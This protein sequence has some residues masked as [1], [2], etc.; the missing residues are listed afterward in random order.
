[1]RKYILYILIVC[2]LFLSGCGSIYSNYREVEQLL[3]IET[4]GFDLLPGGVR[5]TLASG[6]GSGALQGPIKL[7]GTGATISAA[8]DQ[9]R[10]Y[11]FE[12]ELFCSQT[13]SI[14]IGEDAA[15][16]G[17]EEYL[18]YICQ[19]PILRTDVPVFIIRGGSAYESIMESGDSQHGVS[20]ILKGV[21]EYLE[22]RGGSHIFKAAQISRDSLRHGSALCCTLE[23]SESAE[24]PSEGSQN[25]QS[26]SEGGEGA[27]Y[28]LAVSGFGILKDDRLVEYIDKETAIGVSFLINKVGISSVQLKDAMGRDIVLEISGGSSQIKPRWSKD[29]EL[30]GL[31]IALDVQATVT[32][33]N[34]DADLSR[35]SYTRQ[36]TEALEEHVAELCGQ[37][38][39]Q[40]ARLEA[41]F[42][43]LGSQVERHSPLLFRHMNKSFS[44]ALSG[45]EFR[46]AAE[47]RLSHTNDMKESLT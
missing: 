3:V 29:G 16:E 39:R 31:D 8:M 15:R 24:P 14:L 46:I 41:D 19:S 21:T 30:L 11:S 4:M 28:T 22:T 12:D 5:L 27:A 26:G 18:S 35:D 34:D 1:M 17:M 23:Y 33:M 13:N 44:E 2:A 10:N 47:A 6:I 38:L 42:L 40:S 20:E 43:A 32:Q 7:S 25:G 45:L 9:A 37:V 36:L